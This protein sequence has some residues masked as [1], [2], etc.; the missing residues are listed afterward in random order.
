MSFSTATLFNSW[1][2]SLAK[3]DIQ[4]NPCSE[5]WVCPG[6]SSLWEAPRKPPEGERLRWHPKQV[7]KSPQLIY[8]I[9]KEQ[10]LYSDLPTVDSYPRPVSKTQR[11]PYRKL[12]FAPCAFGHDSHF[13]TKD[14]GLVCGQV[15]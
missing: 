4:Y 14:E 5:F 10:Q 7:L 13:M 2:C 3:Q 8:F 6:A 11:S 1:K 15:N 12:P 9:A